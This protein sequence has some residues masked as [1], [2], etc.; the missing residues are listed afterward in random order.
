MANIIAAITSA[1]VTNNMMRV[2]EATS[3]RSHPGKLPWRTSENSV[4]GK[5][6]ERPFHDVV[7]DV[8]E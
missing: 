2:I 7:H 6:R 5:F 1:T 8:G 4:K 3:L